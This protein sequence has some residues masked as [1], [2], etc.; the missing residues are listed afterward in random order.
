MPRQLITGEDCRQVLLA[1]SQQPTAVEV[2]K[3]LVDGLTQRCN[4]AL[5]RVWLVIPKSSCRAC[6]QPDLCA[7]RSDCLQLVA[8]AGQS[9]DGSEWSRLDGKSAQIPFGF[10][11][12]GHIAETRQGVEEKKIS[13]RSAW[14]VDSEWARRERICGLIGQPLL[15]QDRLLGVLAV[16]TRESPTDDDLAWLRAFADHAAAT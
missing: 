9:L 16:F 6:R 7:Q 3:T 10:G 8:S 14:I 13:P 15:F 2:L 5:A 12:V 11:K 1:M 4:A